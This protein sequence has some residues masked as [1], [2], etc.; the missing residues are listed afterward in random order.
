MRQKTAALRDFIRAVTAMGTS[1]ARRKRTRW[2]HG[3]VRSQI[4]RPDRL[5]F[6][7]RPHVHALAAA[8]CRTQRAATSLAARFEQPE[9]F[10]GHNDVLRKLNMSWILPPLVLS[11][12]LPLHRSSGALLDGFA[13][14]H[15]SVSSRMLARVIGGPGGEEAQTIG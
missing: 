11:V 12:T 5:L 1:A 9:S 4:R 14:C 13:F 3:G 2:M 6:P 10:K 8:T 15:L 7:V